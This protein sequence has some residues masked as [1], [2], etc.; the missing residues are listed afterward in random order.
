MSNVFNTTKEGYYER[1]QIGDSSAGF[2]NA[3][4]DV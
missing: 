2:S 1:C 4:Y 3:T